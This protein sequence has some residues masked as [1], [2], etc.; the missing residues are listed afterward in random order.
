MWAMAAKEKAKSKE[1]GGVQIVVGGAQKS[2]WR[3][4]W[5]IVGIVI[6]IAT[7][8][9][10][11]NVAGRSVQRL[12]NTYKFKYIDKELSGPLK[13]STGKLLTRHDWMVYER[14]KH[15]F[16]NQERISQQE[17]VKLSRDQ[18]KLYE[19]VKQIKAHNRD[20]QWEAWK[21]KWKTKLQTIFQRDENDNGGLQSNGTGGLQEK[22][23][24]GGLKPQEK[25]DPKRVSK[26]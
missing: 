25:L 24:V 8:G 2:K 12:K 18:D 20:K 23:P 17:F 21:K 26:L 16:E 1:S 19:K 14:L 4:L 13:L 10:I 3:Y 11:L 22:P 6:V 7:F 15:V 9:I 5:Y